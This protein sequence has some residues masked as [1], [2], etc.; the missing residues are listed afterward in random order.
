M[1]KLLVP[2]L[3]VVAYAVVMTWVA[4]WRLRRE[5]DA[6]SEPLDDPHL[7]AIVRR[8][9][10]AVGVGHLK[11]HVF[12][13]P[14]FNGLAAP[15]GRIFVT[16]GVLE[17][18][19]RGAV[20]AEEVGSIIAHELG[21]V[22]LGHS[23]RRQIDWAGQNA[24]RWGLMMLIGRFVP[25]AGVWVGNLVAS[26]VAAKLSRRDE[27]EADAFA[28]ALMRKAGVKPA[29]QVSMFRKLG[30]MAQPPGGFVWLASHPPLPDRIA[31]VEALHA[32][33]DSGEA[34]PKVSSPE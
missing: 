4:S 7:E 16:R 24:L 13:Q 27:F 6:R 34:T 10:R 19:R 21:H 29:A 8:L 23:R 20:T 25:I 26:L 32:R 12:D 3:L 15:D 30:Q 18:Y 5:L 2:L 22:A 9:G 17:K 1:I 11:A 14:A 28:A 33:W 31:A